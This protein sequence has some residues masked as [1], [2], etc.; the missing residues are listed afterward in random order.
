MKKSEIIVHEM[1]DVLE[2][3]KYSVRNLTEIQE[4]QQTKSN[5]V[6]STLEKLKEDMDQFL[7]ATNE[8][9]IKNLQMERAA[10]LKRISLALVEAG[11]WFNRDILRIKSIAEIRNQLEAF[12]NMEIVGK[13]LEQAKNILNA[14]FEGMNSISD[15]S[16]IKFRDRAIEL[17]PGIRILFERFEQEPAKS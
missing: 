8:G 7:I 3:I 9:S 14:L 2:G 15:E 5:E 13:G 17:N 11:S 10:M 16:Y 6:V 12:V 1:I 4:S